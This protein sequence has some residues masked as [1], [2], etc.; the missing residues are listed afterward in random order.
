MKSQPVFSKWSQVYDSE[1]VSQNFGFQRKFYYTQRV[2]WSGVRRFKRRTKTL[3]RKSRQFSVS[4]E[5]L[6]KREKFRYKLVRVWLD[7]K[8][9]V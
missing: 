6:F 2:R 4:T 1:I 8:S 5:N 9:V 3:G 7:R